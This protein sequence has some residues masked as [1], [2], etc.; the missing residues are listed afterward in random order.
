[1]PRQAWPA[2]SA[3]RE[4]GKNGTFATAIGDAVEAHGYAA[5]VDPNRINMGDSR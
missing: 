1:M 2:K 3:N 4:N 5:R